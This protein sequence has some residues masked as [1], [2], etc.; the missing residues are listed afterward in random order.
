MVFTLSCHAALSIVAIVH[1][2]F[3]RSLSIFCVQQISYRVTILYRSTRSVAETLVIYTY[4]IGVVYL[5]ITLMASTIFFLLFFID[6]YE[7]DEWWVC[8]IPIPSISL[9]FSLSLFLC[10]LL[11]PEKLNFIVFIKKARNNKR[12][13]THT[14]YMIY[15]M[16]NRQFTIQSWC[17]NSNQYFFVSFF[18]Q[19]RTFQ[20]RRVVINR[21]KGNFYYY[22]VCCHSVTNSQYV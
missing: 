11:S 2:R 9:S 16:T 22:H 3:V 21:F 1:V 15:K 18:R 14:Q 12:S 10:L 8:L 6:L 13:Y 19:L 4:N 17:W 5:F 7:C 20:S